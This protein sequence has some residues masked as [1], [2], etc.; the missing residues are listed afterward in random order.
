ML[1]STIALPTYIPF[2][3][4]GETSILRRSGVVVGRDVRE[5]LGEI[6][7]STDMSKYIKS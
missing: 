2:N 7:L 5:I 3:S 6:F 4:V 1:I